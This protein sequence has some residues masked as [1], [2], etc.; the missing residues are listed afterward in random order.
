MK[1]HRHTLFTSLTLSTFATTTTFTVLASEIH[2]QKKHAVQSP[3]PTAFA[4][5]C[6]SPTLVS[7]EVGKKKSTNCA[8]RDVALCEYKL[9]TL[10]HCVDCVCVFVSAAQSSIATISTRARTREAFSPSANMI[11][12]GVGSAPSVSP[13][14]SRSDFVDQKPP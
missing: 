10:A 1:R 3:S 5:I 11:V 8:H 12:I 6:N 2:T 4:Y 7:I 14:L 13:R 9:A